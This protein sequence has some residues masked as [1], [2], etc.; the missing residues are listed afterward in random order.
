MPD[1]TIG[2]H[3]EWS[4]ARAELLEREQELGELDEELAKQRM[5]LPWVRGEKEY[6]FD[7]EDGKKTLV[8]LFDRR[9]QLLIYHLMFGPTY[10]AACPGCTGLA[11]HLDAALVHMNNRDVTLM[12]I[13]RAPIEKLK[14]YKQRMGWTFPWASSFASDFNFDFD[15]SH[16]EEQM[17]ASELAKEIAEAPDWLRDWADSV[18]TDLASGMA[19]SPV[20]TSSPARTEASTTRTRAPLPTAFCSRPTTPSC[21]TRSRPGETSTSRSA[22]TTSTRGRGVFGATI[23]PG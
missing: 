22:A 20:G 18:G 5:E 10:D 7:T 11:D 4:A 8:E 1:H 6:T 13:S 2:K 19:E 14:A 16:T 15:F 3:D 9:S 21:S 12:C 17:K 23:G